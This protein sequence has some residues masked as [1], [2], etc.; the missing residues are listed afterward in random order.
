MCISSSHSVV[1]VSREFLAEHR[2]PS[3]ATAPGVF[4]ASVDDERPGATDSYSLGTTRFLTSL[5][6][7]Q[8]VKFIVKF[9]DICSGAQL[10]SLTV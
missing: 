4:R 6:D 10:F 1:W 8:T 2:L 9:R 3:A 7:A 5:R